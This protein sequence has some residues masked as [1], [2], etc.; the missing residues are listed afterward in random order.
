VTYSQR[1]D[2]LLEV[3]KSYAQGNFEEKVC[4]KA[5][6][7]LENDGAR[8]DVIVRWLATAIVDGLAY[9]NWPWTLAS[10][11]ERKS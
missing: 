11:R 2:A 3:I 9:G 1:K 10:T 5:V 8:E 6:D 4:D 7:K